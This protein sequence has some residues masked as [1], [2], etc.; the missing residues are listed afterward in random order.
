MRSHILRSTPRQAIRWFSQCTKLNAREDLPSFAPKPRIDI[1]HI[2]ENPETHSKNCNERKYKTLSQHPYQITALSEELRLSQRE[3]IPIR[4]RIN[5]NKRL[6][7]HPST[8]DGVEGERQNTLERS[9]DDIIE[10]NRLLESQIAA[11]DAREARLWSERDTLAIELPNLQSSEAPRIEPK[12]L[13]HFNRDAK[14]GQSLTEHGIE[15]DR[16]HVRIGKEFDIIDFPRAATTSGRGW[17]FLKREAVDLEDALVQY[18]K[19][20]ASKYG[21]IKV[22]PPSLVYSHIGSAC[23]FQPR[24]QKGEQPIYR[25]QDNES[26]AGSESVSYS[27]SGTAEIPFAGMEANKMIPDSDLPMKIVGHSRCYRREAGGPGQATRGLYRVKEFT[28]IEMFAWT[29]PG[30]EMEV[31]ETM[32]KVQT[33]I[34]QS[35]GLYCRVLEM[36]SHDLGASAYRKQDIEAYFP[37]RHNYKEG[38]GELTSTSICTDYQTRRLNTRIQK[39]PGSKGKLQFPYTVNGTALAVP[40]VLAALLEYGWEMRDEQEIVRIPEVLHPYMHGIKIIERKKP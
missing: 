15:K 14:P 37:S 36:P 1:N 33:E 22:T 2:C 32:L 12:G 21:F 40:R 23:G 7:A 9:R 19:S 28:K 35:L 4:R 3:A 16:D 18:A 34:L 10:E 39:A 20:V 8:T 26:D 5:S 38:W 13:R 6:L 31:F 24:D 30:N 17:Y 27:L 11:T 25:F 29:A